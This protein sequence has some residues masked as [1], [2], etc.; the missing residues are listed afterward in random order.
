MF[1]VAEG[2]QSSVCITVPFTPNINFVTFCRPGRAQ[3]PGFGYSSDLERHCFKS[4]AILGEPCSTHVNGTG[5]ETSK[6]ICKSFIMTQCKNHSVFIP[7]I[8]CGRIMNTV[9]QH[10]ISFIVFH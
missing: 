6:I 1:S 8:G 5:Q 4:A 10:C 7:H 3:G 9:K 2:T